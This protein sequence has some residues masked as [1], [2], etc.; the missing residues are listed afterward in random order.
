MIVSRRQDVEW[1]EE[2]VCRHLRFRVAIIHS[3]NHEIKNEKPLFACAPTSD[4]TL[5]AD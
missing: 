3:I 5:E 2:E 4:G 1:R